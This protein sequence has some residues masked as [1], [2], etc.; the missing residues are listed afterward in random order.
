M[1][2][3]PAHPVHKTQKMVLLGG[4]GGNSS[5]KGRNEGNSF[6]HTH[7]ELHGLII[8]DLRKMAWVESL[9]P[10]QKISS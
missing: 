6:I 1:Q 5:R 8:N 9:S 3:A 4:K 7:L 2:E 10:R